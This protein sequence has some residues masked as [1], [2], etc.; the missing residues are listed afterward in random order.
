MCII[1]YLQCVLPLC[2]CVFTPL[3]LYKCVFTPLPTHVYLPPS[4]NVYVP[5]AGESESDRADC[6]RSERKIARVRV[7]IRG[8]L[9][10]RGG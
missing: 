1:S 7:R 4:P 8:I 5:P 2:R 3:P 6:A 10:R 9:A